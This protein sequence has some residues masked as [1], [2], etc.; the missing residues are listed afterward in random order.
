MA[1]VTNFFAGANSGGGF[2]NLFTELIDPE[3]FRDFIILKGGP[4][5]GKNTFMREIGIS[6]EQAGY[7]V[8]YLRCSGDPDSLDGVIIP[9]LRCG[10]A[11]GTSPHILEPKYPAAVDR[12]V[13]L[14]KFYDITAAKNDAEEIKQYTRLYQAAYAKAYQAFRAAREIERSA[15][16]SAGFDSAR[17]ER[18]FR[19]ILSREFRRENK[20]ATPGRVTRRFLGSM[21][22]QGYIW[23][24]DSVEVL[25]SRIYEI[26][27]G[28]GFAGQYF[29]QARDAAVARGWDV[30]SCV[31]P[32]EPER[33]E[34][35]IIPGLRLAF[36]ST[37]AHMEYNDNHKNHI[38]L[39]RIR[40]DAL[41]EF[42]DKSPRL[43]TRMTDLLREEGISALREA[44]SA[45]D[46]LES[47]Y[48]P[49][50]DFDG[51]RALAALEAGRL[52]SFR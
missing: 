12:Y 51:V 35:L 2:R 32:E 13:N 20:N 41:T 11:D 6:M 5:V 9:A 45:H 23:R 48:N 7:D 34:H 18:R 16:M 31:S 43:K 17:A 3:I 39:R 22:Y 14:G 21:T 15:A 27:D 38:Q 30:I 36:I 47:V 1:K 8:E 24:F 25:A 37:R 49:Y 40:L 28:F 10:V 42:Q 46:K 44:K 29:K 52:L 19:G 33:I 26:R 4:G 50:V